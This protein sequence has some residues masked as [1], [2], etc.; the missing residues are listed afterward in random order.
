[1]TENNK[2]LEQ[3][4]TASGEDSRTLWQRIRNEPRPAVLW[5]AGLVGLLLLE[6]GA[7]IHFSLQILSAVVTAGLGDGQLSIIANAVTASDQI[8]TLL[9]RETIPNQGYWNGQRWV[10]TFLGLS[11]AVSWAT[12]ATLI[13]L[14]SFGLLWW[15]WRGYRIYRDRYRQADWTP[16]DDQIDRFANHT[17][18][19]F[20]LFVVISFLIMALFAPALGPTTFVQ[21]IQDPYEHQIQYFNDETSTVES[22]SVGQANL[23]AS[24]RGNPDQNVGIMSYDRYDRFHPVGTMPLGVDLLTFLAYGARVSL[25]IGLSSIALAGFIATA[26]G[27][28]TAYYKGAADLITVVTS[29]S[30]QALPV[31]ML[32]ILFVVVFQDTAI[33]EFYSGAVLLVILFALVYWPYLW[34]SIRG[35]ALQVVEKD[36]VDAAESFGQAPRAIMQKHMLPYIVGYLLVYGSMSIGSIIISVAGL[37]YLG[38]GISAPMPEWGRAVSAGQPYVASVSW[39]ITFIPGFLITLVVTGLNAFG[40]GIRDAIDPQ[41]ETSS[42]TEEEVTTGGTGA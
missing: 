16:R 1:M 4:H 32:A 10:G 34:R 18:G 25:F 39:H 14:Y 28:I 42:G 5:L 37:S 26:L 13:Y 15:L 41:S 12:R 29:D 33:A 23:D 3:R 2:M 6:A 7:I 20:G 11:P 19:K 22:V 9:S 36:W 21:N 38:I 8:P 30:V 35:P 31:I 17:W 40:D 24:S 27:L